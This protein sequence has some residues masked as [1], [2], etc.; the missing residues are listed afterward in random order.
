MKTVHLK[1]RLIEDI[2]LQRQILGHQAQL[3]LI[4]FKI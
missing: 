3:N 2:Q 1:W 4:S